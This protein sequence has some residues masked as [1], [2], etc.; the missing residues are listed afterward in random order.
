MPAIK[1]RIGN[2]EDTLLK[3]I[4]TL[5]FWLNLIEDIQK[6]DKISN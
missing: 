5:K 3:V 2:L 4:L 1:D 6:E